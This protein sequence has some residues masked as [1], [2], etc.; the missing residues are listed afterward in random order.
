V[1]GGE[2]CEWATGIHGWQPA[3]YF[4]VKVTKTEHH[5]ARVRTGDATP[6]LV[7]VIEPVHIRAFHARNLRGRRLHD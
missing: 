6:E 7:D 5:K 1:A 2:Q 4:K 3:K